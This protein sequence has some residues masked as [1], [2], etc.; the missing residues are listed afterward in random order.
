MDEIDAIFYGGIAMG[1]LGGLVG[2]VVI[3]RAAQ[4]KMEDYFLHVETNLKN[5][6]EKRLEDMKN[7]YLNYL[8]CQKNDTI[9][10]QTNGFKNKI[11]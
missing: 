6:L 11:S 10:A 4:N 9:Q 8:N 1:G 5:R 7:A 3:I 2:G